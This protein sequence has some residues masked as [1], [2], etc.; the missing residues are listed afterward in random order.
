M[1]IMNWCK[2]SSLRSEHWYGFATEL[3]GQNEADAIKRNYS[4]GGNKK[5]L[6]DLLGTWYR[7][8]TSQD[9]SWQTI[10][11]AL[12]SMSEAKEVLEKIYKECVV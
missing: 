10:V 6:E 11:D 1:D 9:H 8:T 12:K 5:C 3:V 7:T 2:Q 4:G